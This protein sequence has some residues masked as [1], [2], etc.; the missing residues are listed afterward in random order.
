MA[1]NVLL[2]PLCY[3]NVLWHCAFGGID[4]GC[5]LKLLLFRDSAAVSTCSATW[6]VV[7]ERGST[8]TGVR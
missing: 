4:A 5:L 8:L 6:S 2:K 3:G 1:G 7:M